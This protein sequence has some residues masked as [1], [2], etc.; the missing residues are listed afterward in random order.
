M[1]L[2]GACRAFVN[3]SE[4]GSFTVGAAAARMAQSVASRRIAALERHLGDRLLERSSRPAA[5]TPFGRDVLPLAAQLVRVADRLEQEAEA[6]RHAPLR[7]AVPAT[8]G[9]GALAHF[10]AEAHGHG[11]RL[12]PRTAPPAER[13]EL[14]RTRQVR[15]ALLALPPTEAT[16]TVPLGLAVAADPGGRPIY[17]DTLRPGRTDRGQRPRRVWLQAEDDV[18]HIRD[19]LTRLRDAV[20][21]RP[22]QLAVAHSLAAATAEVLSHG[23]ALLCSPAEAGELRL[24]WRPIGELAAGFGRGYALVVA[25]EADADAARVREA[26]G[27]GIARCLG[28]ATER[29]DQAAEVAS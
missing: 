7:L 27:R 2:V 4:R 6:A 8:C 15:A 3:V 17:L 9:T 16:W 26:C 11:L 29:Q 28:A 21:L 22:A 25:D 14:L 23:D 10:I 19:G 18:P 20:G 1:D 13:A 24:H 12:D 5:L